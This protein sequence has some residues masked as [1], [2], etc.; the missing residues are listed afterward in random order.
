MANWMGRAWSRRSMLGAALSAGIAALA[1]ACGG[2]GGS[3]AAGGKVNVGTVS[4]VRASL[5]NQN[6]VRSNDGRLFLLPATDNAVIAVSWKCTHMGCTVSPPDAKSGTIECPCH[7]TKYD[8]KTGVRLSGPANRPLD[9][10]NAVVDSGNVLVDTSQIF[11]RAT[12]EIG[13]TAPLG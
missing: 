7:G 5:A 3:T 6:Y 10:M 13:Q 4:D 8:G 9:Y 11:T 12:F 2:T 1:T